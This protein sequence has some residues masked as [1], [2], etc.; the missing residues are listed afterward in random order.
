MLK[1]T[2]V[3]GTGHVML[4]SWCNSWFHFIR[5]CSDHIQFNTYYTDAEDDTQT[6]GS[7]QYN[8]ELD[9]ALLMNERND[10]FY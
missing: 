1:K 2:S 8:N 3:D 6:T 4:C 10:E 9:Q 7:E 5:D